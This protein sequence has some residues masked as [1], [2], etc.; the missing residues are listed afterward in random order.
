MGRC[1]SQPVLA[2]LGVRR[3]SLTGIRHGPGAAAMRRT[4]TR[5]DGDA[6]DA[7]VGAWLADR[8]PPQGPT[9]TCG[10]G[11]R[12]Q[13]T[14]RGRRGGR[15]VH[16][17]AAMDHTDDAVLAQR[18]VDDTT[19]EISGFQPL[20][21]GLDLAGMVVTADAVHTR[22]EAAE[23]LVTLKAGRLPVHCQGQPARTGRPATGADHGVRSPCWTAPATWPR[24][25]GHPHPE[26]RV[27]MI[28]FRNVLLFP[29]PRATGAA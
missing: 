17:L 26:G 9:S 14:R 12:Q 20:L 8:L 7:A 22:G 29:G 16:L 21:A 11:G 27:T 25:R 2:A 19:K 1:R 15:A 4:L 23:F 5:L 18:Q 3:D 24:A 6:L 28:R 13:R 10:C